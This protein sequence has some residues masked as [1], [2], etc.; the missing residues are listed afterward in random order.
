[1]SN[2]NETVYPYHASERVEDPLTGNMTLIER[3]EIGFGLTKR[4]HFAGLAMAAMISSKFYGEFLRAE[5]GIAK[6]ALKH[7][8]EL[9]AELQKET[10][11]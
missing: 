6:E 8:D 2:A 11:K 1:M 10:S 9:L 3:D 5:E 4:E 7:A